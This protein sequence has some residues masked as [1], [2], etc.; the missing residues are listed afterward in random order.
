[1]FYHSPSYSHFHI[2]SPSLYS[3]TTLLQ[4]AAPL[5]CPSSAASFFSHGLSITVVLKVRPMGQ[6][7]P[8]KHSVWPLNVS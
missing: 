5:F 4:T 8:Q 7:W 6:S 2:I 1:M 3:L